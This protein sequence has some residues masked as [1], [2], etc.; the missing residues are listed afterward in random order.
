M[1]DRT[2]PATPRRRR[3]ARRRGEVARSRDLRTA[4]QLLLASAGLWFLFDRLVAGLADLVHG[5]LV[6]PAPRRLDID[7]VVAWSDRLGGWALEIVLPVLLIPVVAVILADLVQ[8]GFVWAPSAVAPRWERIDPFGG[9][10]RIVSAD[11]AARLIGGVLRIA[12]LAGVAAWFI[13]DRW[14]ELASTATLPIRQLLASI[15]RA[16]L[17]LMA[18]SAGV[19]L[20]LGGLDFL[21]QRWQFERRLRMTAAELREERRLDGVDPQVRHRRRAHRNVVEAAALQHPRETVD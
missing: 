18:L 3:D 7:S 5:S 1:T 8:T 9:F 14:N 4:G 12:L 2:I 17:E 13:G 11:G 6:T 21:F 20:L 15:G 19:L 16:V 10:G